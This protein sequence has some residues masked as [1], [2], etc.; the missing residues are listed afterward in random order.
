MPV[1]AVEKNKRY[2]N[3]IPDDTNSSIAPL[4]M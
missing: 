3:E 2:T 4:Y 1:S